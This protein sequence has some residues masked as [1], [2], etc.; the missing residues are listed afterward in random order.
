MFKLDFSD[1]QSKGFRI[2]SLRLIH[3]PALRSARFTRLMSEYRKNEDIINQKSLMI[4]YLTEN[5]EIYFTLY[6]LFAGLMYLFFVLTFIPVILTRHG[7]LLPSIF[8]SVTVLCW[9]LADK[10]K[11]DFVMSDVGIS[12]AES[13]YDSRIREKYNML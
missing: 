9:F 13:I 10:Y 2:S 3:S 5:S 11:G 12:L 4:A 1:I 6:Y 7:I 8:F